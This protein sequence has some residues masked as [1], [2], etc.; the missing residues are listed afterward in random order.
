MTFL[1][2]VTINDIFRIQRQKMDKVH[3]LLQENKTV[4]VADKAK[5][6]GFDL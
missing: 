3:K 6:D 1:V 2:Y 5:S 4:V